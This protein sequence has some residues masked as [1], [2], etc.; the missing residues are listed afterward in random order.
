MTVTKKPDRRGELEAAV[1]TIAQ[2]K[3]DWRSLSSGA[4]SR[5]PL[6]GPVCSCAFCFVQFAHETAGAARIRLSC[7]EGK[8]IYRKPR[9]H[10]AARSQ[11]C[12]C[13][14]SNAA[15]KSNCRD[16]LRPN[17]FNVSASAFAPG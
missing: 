2:G 7:L 8:E 1:K 17:V 15:V 9:A 5:D 3:S 10:Q 13:E 14:Q 12:V 11:N 6:A 4:R 16:L